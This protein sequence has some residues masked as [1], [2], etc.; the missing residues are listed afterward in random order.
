MY[1]LAALEKPDQFKLFVFDRGLLKHM[2]E[3][4]NRAIFLKSDYKL[5]DPLTENYVFRNSNKLSA[6]R[7][8][9]HYFPVFLRR[10]RESCCEKF[11]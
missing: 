5:K 2:A 10:K 11:K 4:E 7:E 8:Y 6:G 1:P 3:F 9:H